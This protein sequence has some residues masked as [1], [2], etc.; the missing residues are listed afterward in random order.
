MSPGTYIISLNFISIYQ[1]NNIFIIKFL[2]MQILTD[3]YKHEVIKQ[4]YA[5]T[6]EMKMDTIELYFK[7]MLQKE[8][9]N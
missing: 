4:G 6:N 8:F 2:I 5:I 9:K 3:D 7:S 1:L